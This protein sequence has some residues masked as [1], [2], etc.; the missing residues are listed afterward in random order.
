M[1]LDKISPVEIMILQFIV[2]H[3][4]KASKNDVIFYNLIGSLYNREKRETAIQNLLSLKYVATDETDI[5]VSEPEGKAFM[6]AYDLYESEE[7]FAGNFQYAILKFLFEING[8]VDLYDMPA[9]FKT[10]APVQPDGKSNGMNLDHYLQINPE[11]KPYNTHSGVRMYEINNLGKA[12]YQS[13][14]KKRQAPPQN[15]VFDKY[16]KSL[17][18]LY[19]E[20]HTGKESG[21]FSTPAKDLHLADIRSLQPSNPVDLVDKTFEDT[22]EIILQKHKAVKGSFSLNWNKETFKPQIPR[23]LYDVRDE[24]LRIGYIY[25]SPDREK[26]TLLN[27]DL[28]N[29]NSFQECDT[30]FREKERQ[31]K[32]VRQQTLLEK[33]GINADQ[34]KD[35][36]RKK[37]ALVLLILGALLALIK[38]LTGK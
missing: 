7:I 26:T 4:G 18:D 27:Y 30:V 22:F 13:E 36:K 9:I 10:Q 1:L 2:G 12:K 28:Y 35:F 19:Y 37:W 24:M 6:S 14:A 34:L 38:L 23:N 21:R 8:P 31:E 11:M 33:T 32:Q 3:G 15:A 17:G 25:N 5:W 29:C 16:T 20:F